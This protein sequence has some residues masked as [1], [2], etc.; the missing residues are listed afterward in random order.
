MMIIQLQKG[1]P[2]S[3]QDDKEFVRIAVEAC[4]LE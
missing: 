1:I 3:G 2:A 4:T